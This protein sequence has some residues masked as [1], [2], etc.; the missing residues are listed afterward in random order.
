MYSDLPQLHDHSDRG[1]TMKQ[2]RWTPVAPAL[3]LFALGLIG[4]VMAVHI[5]GP[6]ARAATMT[7]KGDIGV[8]GDGAGATG[9]VT[10]NGDAT[11]NGQASVQGTVTI[12]GNVSTANDVDV[13]GDATLNRFIRSY[14]L[15]YSNTA[16]QK[17]KSMGNWDFCSLSTMTIGGL[18]DEPSDVVQCDVANPGGYH[19][20]RPGWALEIYSGS[21]KVRSIVCTATCMSFT[22][23]ATGAAP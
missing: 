10:A 22:T 16:G 23:Y 5:G 17:V 14:T 2:N 15:S 8:L 21:S 12:E 7:V 20:D 9:S 11:V 4:A 19:S 1:G 13:G 6:G 18:G 3:R